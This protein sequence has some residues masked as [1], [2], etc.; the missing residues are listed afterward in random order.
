MQQISVG[1]AAGPH[2][3]GCFIYTRSL[4]KW[5]TVLKCQFFFSGR[6]S[7]DMTSANLAKIKFTQ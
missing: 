1:K 2:E 7:C 4:R 3:Q 6:S 5:K